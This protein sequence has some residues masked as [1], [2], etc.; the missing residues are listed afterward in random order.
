MPSGSSLYSV[1][2]FA[3]LTL[4]SILKR[5][6]LAYA[7]PEGSASRQGSRARARAGFS[8]FDFRCSI[9]SQ[10]LLRVVVSRQRI[11]LFSETHVPSHG[12]PVRCEAVAVTPRSKAD[13]LVNAV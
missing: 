5:C 6:A 9:L 12:F 10:Y 4:G 11:F 8:N 13:R 7:S 3:T 2:R 1:R